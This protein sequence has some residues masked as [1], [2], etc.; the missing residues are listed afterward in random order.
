MP[1]EANSNILFNLFQAILIFLGRPVVQTQ[2]TAIGLIIV[3]AWLLSK[4]LW[5]LKNRLFLY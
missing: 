5:F 4:W 2:L 3:L 1:N